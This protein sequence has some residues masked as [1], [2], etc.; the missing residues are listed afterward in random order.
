[1]DT[2][3]HELCSAGDTARASSCAILP[4]HQ[5]QEWHVPAIIGLVPVMMHMA[6]GIFFAGLVIHTR[7]MSTPIALVVG[8]LVLC[9]LLAYTGTNLVPV[10]NPTCPYKTSLSDYAYTVF[11]YVSPYY[12]SFTLPAVTR[13][14]VSPADGGSVPSGINPSPDI[15]TAR[16]PSLMAAEEQVVKSDTHVDVHCLIEPIRPEHCLTNPEQSSA[17]CIADCQRSYWF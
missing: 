16:P 7:S 4:I 8:G 6:L 14:L 2:S 5:L 12:C 1:M 3:L 15:A 13:T 10:F 17:P 11:R 9:A